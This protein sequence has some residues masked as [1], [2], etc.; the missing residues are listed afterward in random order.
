MEVCC[1]VCVVKYSVVLAMEYVCV[2]CDGC[3]VSI[4]L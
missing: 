3:C 1:V 4:V 2:R